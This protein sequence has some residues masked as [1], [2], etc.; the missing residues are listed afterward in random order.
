MNASHESLRRP[1][2]LVGI[3]GR[4]VKLPHRLGIPPVPPPRITRRVGK[5]LHFHESRRDGWLIIGAHEM[6]V[7]IA[8]A[9]RAE[10]G[11]RVELL[12]SNTS[13]ILRAREA[14]LTAWHVD[15]F[16]MGI[17]PGGRQFGRIGN[18]LAL[19]DNPELNRQLV[20]RWA[21]EFGTDHVFGWFAG[22][23]APHLAPRSRVLESFPPPG[24]LSR[25]VRDG[26]ARI[27]VMTGYNAEV[28]KMVGI[29]VLAVLGRHRVRFRSDEL[30]TSTSELML[31]VLHRHRNPPH[32]VVE[33]AGP[34]RTGSNPA[35]LFPSRIDMPADADAGLHTAGL[36]RPP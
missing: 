3:G 33:A 9:V 36:A 22:G 30:V 17:V 7:Q 25:E 4:L 13:N 34:P 35:S 5:W 24:V 15:A 31:L 27:L 2:P 11:V 32:D 19:T 12:D 26:V 14:G 20:D 29:E 28:A 23:R 10:C 16:E 8:Q 21:G 18:L 6:A 1:G